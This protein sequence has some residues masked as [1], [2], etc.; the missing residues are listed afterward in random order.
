MQTK[1]HLKN[2]KFAEKCLRNVA[3]KSY[4]SHTEPIYKDLNILKLRDKLEY[5]RSVF[6]HQYKNKKLPISFSDI[7]T[8]ITNTD[9]LQTRHN[10]YNFLIKPAIKRHLETFPLRQILHNWN[11]L[12]L[13]LKATANADEFKTLLKNKLSSHYSYETDCP[14]N[15]FSCRE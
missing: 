12:D 13:E 15:C 8:D 11:S 6:M 2:R 3:L 1:T 10:D 5:C 7:Y 9:E 14:R 4:K